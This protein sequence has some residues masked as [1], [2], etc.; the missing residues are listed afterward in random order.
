MT[1]DTGPL[2]YHLSRRKQRV[3]LR[4]SAFWL[5]ENTNFCGTPHNKVSTQK[6]YKY[7]LTMYIFSNIKNNDAVYKRIICKEMAVR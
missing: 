6:V 7:F 3:S 1:L 5:R 4:E 2:V